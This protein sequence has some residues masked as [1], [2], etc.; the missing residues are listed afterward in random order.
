V[1]LPS[2]VQLAHAIDNHEHV[3]C[4]S[5][6]QQH[7]HERSL[8][9]HLLHRQIQNPTIDFPSAL[10]VIPEHFYTFLFLESP[11][12]KEVQFHSEK[13]SRGP[14]FLLFAQAV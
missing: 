2:L 4:T 7:V 5:T 13:T 1:L 14:P 8:D 6:D 12:K 9:C 3:V 11:Q 10:E